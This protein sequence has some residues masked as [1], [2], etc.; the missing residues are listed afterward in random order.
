[1]IM[2]GKTRKIPFIDII[3]D[4]T[5]YSDLKLLHEKED[6][7][8]YLISQNPKKR[9]EWKQAILQEKLF[10]IQIHYCGNCRY[11]MKDLEWHQK[12]GVILEFGSDSI[13]YVFT[14]SCYKSDV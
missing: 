6:I 11:R 5:F 1:M 7:A 4:N 8:R 13:N 10:F 3:N 14:C 2:N 12:K 9:E